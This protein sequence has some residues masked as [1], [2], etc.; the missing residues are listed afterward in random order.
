MPYSAGDVKW[1]E[2]VLGT[3]SGTIT[4][5]ADYVDAL[6]FSAN[7]TA[8]DFDAALLAAFDAWESVASVDFQLVSS[9]ST[10]DVD[11]VSGSLG[12][13]AGTASI[14]FDGNAGLSEI[15]SGTVTFNTDLT[16]SPYGQFGGVDFY[17]V[18]LHEI[19]HILGLGHVDDPTEIM[20][21]VIHADSLGS[22]DIAGVQFLYGSDP[23]DTQAPESE[24]PQG[25]SLSTGGGGGGGGAGLL[26]GLLAAL[27]G[28]LLGGGAAAGAALAASFVPENNDEET[29]EGH[30]H[31]TDA[32]GV[33]D[34]Q[35]VS[36]LP[37]D[38]PLPL[39]EIEDVFGPCGCYGPCD[40]AEHE[41]HGLEMFA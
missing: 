37:P 34:V 7:Y 39:I 27:I 3:P 9:T 14:T 20:N 18:A 25:P 38:L 15:F 23:G 6:N 10:S 41:A 29:D 36:Y 24:T 19:G 8:A 17:A 4:W 28:M 16:W 5:S 1:G 40:C 13:A 21:P 35:H 2:P 11:V 12:G 31:D 33:I 26:I 30:D 32:P 22:G